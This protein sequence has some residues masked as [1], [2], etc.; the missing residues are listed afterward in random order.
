MRQVLPLFLALTGCFNTEFYVDRW[1]GFCAERV[2]YPGS[3]NYVCVKYEVEFTCEKRTPIFQ[4]D[5]VMARCKTAEECETK[6]KEA[7][8]EW[9]KGK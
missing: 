9:E 7:K 5:T 2:V 4:R 3:S 1:D 6:C 8:A